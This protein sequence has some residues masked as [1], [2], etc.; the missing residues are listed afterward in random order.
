MRQYRIILFKMGDLFTR[1][2]PRAVWQ[3]LC[4]STVIDQGER[5]LSLRSVPDLEEVQR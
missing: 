3:C 5:D 2:A 4:I 1:R